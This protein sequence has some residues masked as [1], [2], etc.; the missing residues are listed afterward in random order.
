MFSGW[1]E[2]SIRKSHNR[3][4][5]DCGEPDLNDFLRHHARQN[6][7]RG[8]SK[9]FVALDDADDNTILGY[10]SLSPASIGYA[11]VPEMISRTQ[12]R[13]DA[14]GFRLARLAVSTTLQGQGLGGQLLAAAARRCLLV[15]AEV[16]GT[17]LVIDAKS[18]RAADWYRTYGAVPTHDAPLTLV[19]PLASL[20]PHMAKAGHI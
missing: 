9:T 13:Y 11:R 8:V 19:L 7:E 4:D 2:E 3:A 14:G 18:E 10:Y 1:H 6:H 15:A 12:G 20:T 17:I 16:G 5:F